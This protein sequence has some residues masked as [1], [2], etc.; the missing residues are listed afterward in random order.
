MKHF[1][2]H[3]LKQIREILEDAQKEVNFTA[4]EFLTGGIVSGVTSALSKNS[5]RPWGT[6]T[7]EDYTSSWKFT[8][9][10]KEYEQFLP[11]MRQGEALL[12][13]CSLQE[14]IQY[15][16]KGQEREVSGPKEK[17]VRILSI[18]LLANAKESLNAI[19]IQLNVEDI[20]A[21][22]RKELVRVL[23]AN[24]GKITVH[25]VLK[26]KT[27]KMAVKLFSRSHRIDLTTDFLSWLDKK[28][29]EFSV[30]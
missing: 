12:V 14:R 9:F 20:T 17:E 21:S 16:R 28:G 13:R 29:L 7:L 4:R 8:L 24:P 25:F 22:F 26:D 23:S 10:G 27:N 19:S 2:S 1:T 5:G 15:K 18:S 6:F 3:S 30:E 11:Y